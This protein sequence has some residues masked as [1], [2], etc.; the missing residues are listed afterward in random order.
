MSLR[1]GQ[2]KTIVLFG[3]AVAAIWGFIIVSGAVGIIAYDIQSHLARFQ[4]TGELTRTLLYEE[5]WEVIKE[6]PWVGIGP[7]EFLANGE[8]MVMRPWGLSAVVPHNNLLGMAAQAG[9]PAAGAYLLWIL[10][11]VRR[12]WKFKSS[13]IDGAGRMRAARYAQGC[14]A[15]IVYQ[16]VFGLFH[17]TWAI[18]EQYLWIGLGIGLW[19]VHTTKFAANR[20]AEESIEQDDVRESRRQ[21]AR[22]LRVA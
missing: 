10:V 8:F 19:Q 15:V 1:R 18:K 22:N 2:A 5:L 3:I 12:L 11:V 7:G 6:K 9:L 21:K 4:D 16:Q 20:A 17:D 14:L 13:A